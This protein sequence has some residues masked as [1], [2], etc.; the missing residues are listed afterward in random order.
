MADTSL[1]VGG[2]T[3]TFQSGDIDFVESD[4]ASSVES[5]KITKTG[6][7]GTLNYDFDGVLKT[8]TIQGVLTP[9][10][11]TRVSGYSVTSVLS[12]KQ[13]LESLINGNQGLIELTDDYE[14]QSVLSDSGATPPFLGS[15]TSTKCKNGNIKFRR[16]RGLVNRLK[17][18]LILV[19]GN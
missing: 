4:I 9:A 12:Q 5:T 7:M 1:T 14:S 17:F 3:F 13:W 10:A 11:T 6:S 18:T 8:I 16:E 19:V 2:Y 15:F